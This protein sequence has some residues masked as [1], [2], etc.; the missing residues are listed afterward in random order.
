MKTIIGYTDRLSVAPGETIRF[1]VS[2]EGATQN[3]QADVVRLLCAD[4]NPEGRGFTENIIDAS[5]NGSYAGRRQALREGSWIA[6]PA[7]RDFEFSHGLTLQAYIYPTTPSK[8]RQG[9]IGT[10]SE[11][12]R[13]GAALLIDER[14]CLALRAG[15]SKGGAI[16]V[17]TGV[18]LLGRRWQFVCASLNGETGGVRLLQ[19]PLDALEVAAG[20]AE[21]E[22]TPSGLDFGAAGHILT[23]AALHRGRDGGVDLVEACFNGKI[24][25]PRVAACSMSAQEC[26][27]LQRIP[28]NADGNNA[29]VGAWDFSADIAGDRVTDISR[30]AL[31]GRTVNL[32]TRAVTGHNWNVDTR[33]WRTAPEQYGAIHFHDDDLYDAGWEAD[34]AWTIPDDMRSGVYALRVDDGESQDRIVFFVRPPRD[35]ATARI[36]YLA[37]TATYMAYANTRLM[38]RG[39]LFEYHDGGAIVLQLEDLY[40]MEHPEVGPSLYEHH[41]DG[42]GVCYSSWLRPMLNMRPNNQLWAFNGDNLLTDW[43]DV[44]GHEVDVICDEDLD[45]EGADLLRRYAVVITGCHAEYTSLRMWNA[46]RDYVAGGGRTMN[47]GG[48]CFYWRIAYHPTIPGVI[49]LRR[50][51]PGPWVTQPGEDHHSFSGEPG[52]LWSRLGR[53]PQ[54]L[55]GVGYCAAGMDTGSYYRQGAARRD[56]RWSFVFEGVGEEERIGDFGVAGGAA[57][58]EIDCFD[59]ALGSPHDTVVLATSEDHTHVMHEGSTNGNVRTPVRADLVICPCPN[60]GAIF[61]TGSISWCASLP[62]NRYSNNVSRITGN[63]LG[64]FL[65][66]APL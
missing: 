32:P 44:M 38:D 66:P 6:V 9:L 47:L 48:N 55:Q 27:A 43:L 10:W 33:D 50:T 7:H 58:Q 31:H 28:L 15:D 36:A 64:R 49:E 13:R 51:S 21:L 17:S 4:D 54:M 1:H 20:A 11:A 22:C 52:G 39:S 41:T 53:P 60:G 45:A 2:C 18:P 29:L 62:H 42:S 3:Y 19:R 30:N 23:M 40:V 16:E 25:A 34:S 14:G 61:S 8:G 57:G 59:L 65:D 35:R 12:D 26:D 56:P 63:V 37:S 5:I 24:D 46:L